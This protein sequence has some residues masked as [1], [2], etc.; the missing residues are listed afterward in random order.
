ME[1]PRLN[2]SSIIK[3]TKIAQ[4]MGTLGTH[5]SY[6]YIYASL[7][8]YTPVQIFIAIRADFHHC[9][10]V[11]NIIIDNGF[12]DFDYIKDKTKTLKYFINE[13]MREYKLFEKQFDDSIAPIACNP[14][15]VMHLVG[16]QRHIVRSYTSL[17]IDELLK[18]GRDFAGIYTASFYS[19]LGHTRKCPEFPFSKEEQYILYYLMGNNEYREEVHSLAT[20]MEYSNVLGT[21]SQKEEALNYLKRNYDEKTIL[22]Q[23]GVRMRDNAQHIFNYAL[24]SFKMAYE[25]QRERFLND[26]NFNMEVFEKEIEFID[27]SKPTYSEENFNNGV[28]LYLPLTTLLEI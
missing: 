21:P 12:Y 9:C 26:G 14:I 13:H 4:E 3:K 19:A 15:Q 5:Y 2:L 17:Q 7:Y 10:Q 20:L 22:F 1:I 8:G 18:R 11:Q 25:N 16:R 23:R 28:S 6:S 24:Y 27:T